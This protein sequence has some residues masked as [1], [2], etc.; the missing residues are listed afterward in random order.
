MNVLD[1]N[2]ARALGMLEKYIYTPEQAK[3][4][5]EENERIKSFYKMTPEQEEKERFVSSL[6]LRNVP[7]L[8]K[9]EFNKEFSER[10][11]N[12]SRPPDNEISSDSHDTEDQDSTDNIM[13]DL[14]F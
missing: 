5:R 9:K 1:I 10:K 4:W 7:Y 2:Y 12:N 11:K 3:K 6:S 14:P 8:S 13:D